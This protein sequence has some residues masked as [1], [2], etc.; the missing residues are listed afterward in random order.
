MKG[1]LSSL[2]QSDWYDL[3]EFPDSSDLGLIPSDFWLLL[4]FKFILKH[5]KSHYLVLEYPSYAPRITRSEE[6]RECIWSTPYSALKLEPG[7]TKYRIISHIRDFFNNFISANQKMLDQI[8]E[9]KFYHMGVSH[10]SIKLLD[11][12]LELK[13][14]PREPDKWKCFFVK[15]YI[16]SDLDTLGKYNMVDPECLMPYRYLCIEDSGATLRMPDKNRPHLR[17]FRGKPLSTNVAYLFLKNE[18]N[19]LKDYATEVADSDFYYDENGILLSFDLV[20]FGKFHHK[21]KAQFKSFVQS[22]SEIAQGFILQLDSI[23]RRNL[24]GHGFYQVRLEGDGFIASSPLR[25]HFYGSYGESHSQIQV[26]RT[27]SLLEV[28]L[29]EINNA[30]VLSNMSFSYRSVFFLDNYAYGKIGGFYS[31]KADFAGASLIRLERMQSSLRKWQQKK[32]HKEGVSYIGIEPKFYDI[33][34]TVFE[35]YN[36]KYEEKIHIEEKESKFN[37]CVLTHKT[38]K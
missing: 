9:Y 3:N 23:F 1:T 32:G 16:I 19:L 5:R 28:L 24:D 4:T 6:I 18:A 29:K 36:F 20:S 21:V 2:G 15:R 13:R 34:K 22:G 8:M 12:I 17:L 11:D 38:K 33:Y 14:S 25:H 7:L 26:E 35:R 30:I 27:L 37:M 31:D 10:C